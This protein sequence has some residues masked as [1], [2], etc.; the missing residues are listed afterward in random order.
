MQISVTDDGEIVIPAEFS[1]TLGLHP[2]DSLDIAVEAG[3]IV[4]AP[5]PRARHTGAIII[6]PLTGW[7]VLDFGPDAPELTNEQ[8]LRMLADFR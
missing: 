4:L 2:G 5:L 1:E 3:R 6:D 8:V 7:P